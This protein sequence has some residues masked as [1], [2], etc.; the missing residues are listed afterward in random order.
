M[1]CVHLWEEGDDKRMDT[2]IGWSSLDSS[3]NQVRYRECCFDPM[4]TTNDISRG[5]LITWH[6]FYVV[7]VYT[8][9]PRGRLCFWFMCVC[10]CAGYAC[11]WHAKALVLIK[12]TEP[13][14]L[15]LSHK[16]THTLYSVLHPVPRYRVNDNLVSNLVKAPRQWSSWI[17]V[18]EGK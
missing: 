10:A 12:S 3:G 18:S 8:A 1:Q 15:S 2:S 16:H 9:S 14:V 7:V 5:D 13:Y 4:S 17:H 11:N 6:G